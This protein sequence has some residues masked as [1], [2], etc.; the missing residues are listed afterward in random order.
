M[1]VG[2]R[3]GIRLGKDSEQ[4]Q[5]LSP[6]VPSEKDMTLG[7]FLRQERERRGL[8]IEQ[9]GSA[10][11][12]GVRTLHY[13]EADHFAE[14]PARPFIR[15]FVTSYCRFLGLEPK[16]ILSRFEDYIQKKSIERPN[17]EGGHSGYAFE[18]KDGEQQSRTVLFIAVVSFIVIGG[19]AMLFVKPSLRH[20]HPSHMDKLRTAHGEL[21]FITPQM[22]TPSPLASVLAALPVLSTPA[23][24]LAISPSTSLGVDSGPASTNDGV[25]SSESSKFGPGLNPADPLDSGHSLSGNQVHEKVVVK[26]LADIWVR[27]Q[28]DDRSVR[29]FI[30]RKGKT[31]ILRGQ[32][33]VQVQV[34]NSNSATFQYNG[35]RSQLIKDSKQTVIKQG[36]STLIFPNEL[37]EKGGKSFVD[38]TPLPE[39]SD[40]IPDSLGI[41]PSPSP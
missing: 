11:K 39:T 23:S 4:N 22:S 15:G 6:G 7:E 41:V 16:E 27:Y 36:V 2:R 21:Q 37:A 10:T 33:S 40:P 3:L 12:V 29:K 8:T 35:R 18:K 9:V 1:K 31:L 20:R 24:P 25:T 28:V 38:N 26:S 34:S 32:E 30:V 13:L 17:R 19:F 14:L 5:V